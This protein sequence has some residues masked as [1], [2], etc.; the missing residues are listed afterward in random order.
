MTPIT[1]VTGN[2]NKLKEL[3]AI[4]PASIDFTSQALDLIEIQTL[5]LHEIVSHKLREAYEQVRGPVIVEDVSA[6]LEKLNGLPGP[7]IKFF[8]ERMGNDSL[9]KLGGEGP[10]KVTCTMGYFDGTTEH[11]VDGVLDGQV[12]APRDGSG[13]GFGFVVVP[14][15]Y[16]QTMSQMSEEQRNTISHRAKAANAMA[17]YLQSK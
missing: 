15:G 9:Y 3:L 5:D 10:V 16:D 17:E 2:P 7:F 11:I 1:I 12:V 4:F 13:F 6:E 14:D 8:N